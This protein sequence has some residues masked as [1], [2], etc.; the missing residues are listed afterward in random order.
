MDDAVQAGL[1]PRGIN[2]IRVFPG[3]GIRVYGA[4]TVSSD[5]DWR[6]VN[7]RRLIMMIEEALDVATQWVVFEPNDAYTRGKVLLCASRL[8]WKRSGGAAR[9]PGSQPEQAFF[10]KCDEEN[11]LPTT[12]ERGACMRKSA[13]RPSVPYEFVVLR[14]GR[15]AEEFEITEQILSSRAMCYGAGR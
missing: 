4:R 5:P 11:N 6:Y 15:T 13:L 8:F 3:R 12:R 7:V 10:V 2:A 14:V 9:L 1:N